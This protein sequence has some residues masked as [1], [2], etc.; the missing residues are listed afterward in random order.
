MEIQLDKDIILKSD[1]MQFMLKEI[2]VIQSGKN[3][4][5]TTEN[6]IG[7]YGEIKHALNA[8]VKYRQLNSSA[9][10]IHELINETR[11]LHEYIKEIFEKGKLK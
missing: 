1:S 4:G 8:Y 7:F 10:T 11:L 3:E 2:K 9:T 5:E 6:V